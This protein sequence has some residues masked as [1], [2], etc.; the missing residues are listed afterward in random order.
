MRTTSGWDDAFLDEM[1]QCGD[2]PADAAV[3]TIDTEADRAAH[4][5][6]WQSLVHIDELVSDDAPPT[7]TAPANADL[8]FM[9]VLSPCHPRLPRRAIDL[10]HAAFADLGG[11]GV[12]AETG[13]E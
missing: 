1:R 7:S 6:F 2:L 9:V 10:T 12:R 4:N 13:A 5:R 3:T 11:D 8:I